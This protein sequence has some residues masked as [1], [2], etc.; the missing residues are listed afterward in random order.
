ML[1]RSFSLISV[2]GPWPLVPLC[3]PLTIPEPVHQSPPTQPPK[4]TH[5]S[6]RASAKHQLTV[7]LLSTHKHTAE[8]TVSSLPNDNYTLNSSTA[9]RMW[10]LSQFE[11]IRTMKHLS[12]YHKD[13]F[14]SNWHRSMTSNSFFFFFKKKLP[15]YL[16]L[17]K[18]WSFVHLKKKHKNTFREM[19]HNKLLQFFKRGKRATTLL[20]QHRPSTFMVFIN[21]LLWLDFT[22]NIPL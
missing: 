11:K 1:H 6:V 2:M 10:F 14:Y 20:W 3:L 12:S 21:V 22:P 13:F 17:Q 7:T 8:S 19:R 18:Q 5:Q 15:S 9:V 16:I 4:Q